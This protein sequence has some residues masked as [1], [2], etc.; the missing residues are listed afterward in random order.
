MYCKVRWLFTHGHLTTF[1]KE[2]ALADI[3][4]CANMV[5]S[6]DWLRLATILQPHCMPHVGT[7][8]D[9]TDGQV[10]ACRNDHSSAGIPV[11]LRDI[12]V[13]SCRAIRLQN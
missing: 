1:C 6:Y 5:T 2:V 3:Y 13:E 4:I 12:A 11:S 10:Y 7:I 9:K 8:V